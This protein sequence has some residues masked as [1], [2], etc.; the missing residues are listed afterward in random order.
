MAKANQKAM[1]NA[2]EHRANAHDTVE[3]INRI[4]KRKGLP[5]LRKSGRDT[6]SN[7]ALQRDGVYRVAK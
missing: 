3:A 7:I 6:R 2:E 1:G 4:R 5:E